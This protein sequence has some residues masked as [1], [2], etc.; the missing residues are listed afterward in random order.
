M[1]KI[2]NLGLV[3]LVAVALFATSCKK[4]PSAKIYNTWKMTSVEMPDADSVTLSQLMNAEVTYTFK[5]N[6]TYSY[7]I[8][9]TTGNGTFEIN[10]EATTLT[11]VEE[12]QTEMQ[13]V[14]LTDN[15]L[16]LSKG[17]EKMMFTVKK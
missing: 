8:Q 7:D 15:S 4:K 3:A 16:Q 6:G 10:D 9:G 11:T 13:N 14:M 17:N 12:G 5:K 1:K 2:K